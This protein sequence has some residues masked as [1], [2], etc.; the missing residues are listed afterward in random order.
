M[1]E[2]ALHVQVLTP[3]QRLAAAEHRARL[4]NIAS[5]A[6][7]D[8]A[9]V[10]IPDAGRLSRTAA[11]ITQVVP[12]HYEPQPPLSIWLTIAHDV[13]GSSSGRRVSIED[14]QAEVARYFQT[15][16]DELCAARRTMEAVHARQV[17]MYLSWMLLPRYSLE[18]IGKRFGGRDHTTVRHAVRKIAANLPGDA[19][20]AR[21]IEAITFDLG[22]SSI[23]IL[24]ADLL[25]GAGGSSTGL[26]AG[27]ADLGLEMELVCVNHWPS[28]SRPTQEP[29]GG[30]ALLPG[31]RDGAAAHHRAGRLSRPADGLADLHAPFGRA[32]RQADVGPAALSDPWHIITWLT[33]L[34]V[35]RMII[36]N[37]WEFIGWGPVDPA[38]ASRSSRARANISGHGSTPSGG[39]ASSRNGASSTPPTTATPRRASASS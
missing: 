37:V 31:H 1:S 4:A 28:R 26:R 10:H 6:R 5:R 23:T 21:D 24:V 22:E 3:S 7:I 36:E 18:A 33:E 13:G 8:S 27:A 29:S 25:C 17:A 34:R 19:V 20:L 11:V 30:A 15:S 38:P 32:R 9:V 2:H 35:K 39:S 14:I 12:L 16:I